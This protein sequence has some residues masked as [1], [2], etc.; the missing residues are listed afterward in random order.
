MDLT[1]PG[2]FA[3]SEAST[4][5]AGFAR[6]RHFGELVF[7]WLELELELELVE[8]FLRA[9]LSDLNLEFKYYENSM[10]AG[11]WQCWQWHGSNTD[12]RNFFV[13][14]CRVAE[15]VP[16][17]LW[18]HKADLICVTLTRRRSS[19]PTMS[20]STSAISRTRKAV[21]SLVK[22]CES[23]QW[24]VKRVLKDCFQ[25]VGCG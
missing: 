13:L 20:E 14:W 6:Q 19:L 17:Y 1:W 12:L 7:F 3:R 4:S 22:L 24:N 16:A 18:A 8:V 15:P 2:C 21:Y 5:V 25:T 11:A 10:N 9:D 23:K